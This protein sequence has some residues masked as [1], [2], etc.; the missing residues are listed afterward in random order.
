L[1]HCSVIGTCLSL[2]ELRGLCCRLSV[3]AAAPLT[4]YE[5]HRSF[6]GVAGGR[7]RA[8]RRL[9]KHLDRKYRATIRRY[10]RALSDTALAG[11]WDEA[12]ESGAPAGAY[13]ALVTHP[14]ASRALC[15]RAYGDVHML[16]HRALEKQGAAVRLDRQEL[17]RLR[18]S[19]VALTR[20]LADAA[21]RSTA[22]VAARD[23][24]IHQLQEQLA[25]ARAA[26]RDLQATQARLENTPPVHRLRNQVENYAARLAAERLRAE[27]AEAA[28]GEWRQMAMEQGDR[29]LRLE[30]Q[31]A[32]L[33]AERDALEA[34]LDELLSADCVGR[35]TCA[36]DTNLRGRC[37]LYVGGI[38]RQC[39]RFR[40]L[41][42]RR[43]GRFVHHDGG[44][45][46]GRL[47]LGS[48]L[49]QADAVFCPVDCVSHDA[50]KRVKQFCKRHGKRLVLLPR[51]SLAA[52]TRG[53]SEVAA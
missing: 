11:L 31:L 13:W 35:G 33:G 51:A 18:H 7:T 20:Q 1:W 2:A 16:S 9:H 3:T 6:V 50:A 29:H 26:T 10:A 14:R 48:I 30:R 37:I 15:D 39:G 23:A 21:T 49:P 25:Q 17:T 52:F 8:A 53:L 24:T 43:N 41:V 46:D 27:R 28:A 44:L 22:Q 19:A 5:L 12:V 4:D 38:D 42:E 40:D 34:K 47:R 32:E 36:A 45:H